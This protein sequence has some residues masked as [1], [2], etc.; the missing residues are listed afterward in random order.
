MSA[1]LCF[2]SNSIFLLIVKE[3]M[4]PYVRVLIHQTFFFTFITELIVVTFL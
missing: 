4:F 3:N 1:F 2:Y